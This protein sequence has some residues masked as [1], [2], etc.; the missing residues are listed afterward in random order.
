MVVGWITSKFRVY[1]SNPPFLHQAPPT[2]CTNFYPKTSCPIFNGLVFF[3]RCV[4][5]FK[6]FFWLENITW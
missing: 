1:K 3:F 5:F 2:I 4:L 6:R